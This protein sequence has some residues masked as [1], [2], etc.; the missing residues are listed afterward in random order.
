[1]TLPDYALE[2]NRRLAWARYYRCRDDLHQV[3]LWA[4]ELA[5]WVDA[6]TDQ[7]P[8]AAAELIELITA[9]LSWADRQAIRR[10]VRANLAEPAP[11]WRDDFSAVAQ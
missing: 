9:P 1:M 3:S 11:I 6:L 8:P 5:E 10:Y 2:R 7:V 4:G